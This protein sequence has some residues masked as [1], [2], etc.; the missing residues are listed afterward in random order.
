MENQQ[1]QT[2]RGHKELKISQKA[3][4]AAM[5][6]FHLSKKFPVQERYSLTDQIRRSLLGDAGPGAE[7]TTGEEVTV[8]W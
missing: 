2:I 1:K 3:F 5:E 6:I 4:D 7:K 8:H